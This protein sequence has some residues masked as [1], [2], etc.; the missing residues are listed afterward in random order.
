MKNLRQMIRPSQWLGSPKRRKR[1]QAKHANLR[2]LRN[3]SLE[4]RELLAGDVLT[5]EVN[6]Q[7][8]G[9]APLDTNR[10]GFVSPGDVMTIL[11]ALAEKQASGIASGEEAG[12]STALPDVT[13]DGDVTPMDALMVIN[14]LGLNGP[15]AVGEAVELLLT[16]RDPVTYDEIDKDTS[17]NYIVDPFEIFELEVSYNDLRDTGALG[18]FTAYLDL[19]TSDG[20]ILTPVLTEYQQLNF[21]STVGD[22]PTEVYTFNI[23]GVLQ[24]TVTDDNFDTDAEQIAAIETALTNFGYAADEFNVSKLPF[25]G[26]TSPVRFSIQYPKFADAQFLNQDLP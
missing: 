10:D 4:K 23:G 17:G 22:T 13:N 2:R 26:A 9:L 7:H 15:H 6:P 18:V 19:E 20:N 16:A 14:D 12:S 1:T 21:D 25:T 8:N 11:Q 5:Y 3:E 24:H